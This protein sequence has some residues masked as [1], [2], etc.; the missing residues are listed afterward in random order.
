MIPADVNRVNRTIEMN[1][2]SDPTIPE[3]SAAEPLDITE[4]A[5]AQRTADGHWAETQVIESIKD[6]VL[7]H[8]SPQSVLDGTATQPIGDRFS[9]VVFGTDLW[10]RVNRKPRLL[11]RVRRLLGY[12]TS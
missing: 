12:L 2:T 11:T 6:A 4:P 1:S 8:K 10:V 3:E 9:P 7:C 5:A